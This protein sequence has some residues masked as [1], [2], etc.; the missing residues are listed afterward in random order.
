M[1]LTATPLIFRRSG[2]TSAR[3]S[4]STCRPLRSNSLTFPCWASSCVGLSS[5]LCFA[6]S[7]CTWM[8]WSIRGASSRTPSPSG[9]LPSVSSRMAKALRSRAPHTV[10]RGVLGDHVVVRELAHR[11]ADVAERARARMD[12]LGEL[13][14]ASQDVV[15]E[16]VRALEQLWMIRA[17]I[18]EAGSADVS[19]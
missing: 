18:P 7:I 10:E 3:R 11:L 14:A 1:T 2:L 13:D 16:V 5:G 8:R 17:S 15:I 19:G 6:R 4:V 12:R 9:P